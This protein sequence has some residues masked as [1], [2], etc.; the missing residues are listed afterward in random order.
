MA[1]KDEKIKEIRRKNDEKIKEIGEKFPITVAYEWREAVIRLKNP[2]KEFRQTS[3]RLYPSFII[4]PVF[5]V[6]KDITGEEIIPF[7]NFEKRYKTNFH[8]VIGKDGLIE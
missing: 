8:Y 4:C 2:C 5:K 1:I 6:L 3:K 7:H